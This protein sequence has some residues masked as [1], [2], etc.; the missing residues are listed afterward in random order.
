M[1]QVFFLFAGSEAVGLLSF[2]EGKGVSAL[3]YRFGMAGLGQVISLSLS[4]Q[5]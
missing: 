3:L 1:P 2:S 5:N 4:G